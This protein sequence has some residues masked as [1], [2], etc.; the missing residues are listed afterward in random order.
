VAVIAVA[1]SVAAGQDFRQT[2][3]KDLSA[4]TSRPHRLAGTEPGLEA[5][6]YVERRLRQ[7]GVE[8]IYEQAVPV[9]Q[10]QQTE[11]TLTVSDGESHDIYALRP[12][13]LQGVVTP[14]EGLSG[15]T[16]YAGRGRLDEYTEWPENRIV[17]LEWD[18]GNY[19][20]PAFAMGAKAVIFI[21]S[22]EPATRAYH[23]VDLPAN[24][25][26]FYVPEPLAERLKL[27]TESVPV[28]LKAACRWRML[29]GRNV[30]GVIRGT[31]PKFDYDRDEAIVLAAPLDSYGEVPALARGARGAANVAALLALAE[32]LNDNRPRRDVILAFLDGESAGHTGSRFFYG[33]LY[34]RKEGGKWKLAPSSLDEK[35]AMLREE[36][37][38]VLRMIDVLKVEDM[39]SEEAGNLRGY[40]EAIRYLKDEALGLSGRV[41]DELFILRSEKRHYEKLIDRLK[42]VPSIAA[43]LPGAEDLAD[44]E[45]IEPVLAKYRAVIEHH[46]GRIAWLEANEQVAWGNIQRAVQKGEP[47]SPVTE[48]DVKKTIREY[49]ELLEGPSG[50]IPEQLQ[51]TE[52]AEAE[53]PEK[54][55]TRAVTKF[56]ELVVETRKVLR[57]RLREVESHLKRAEQAEKLSEAIGDERNL[58]V[59]H[60]SLNLGDASGRWTMMHGEDARKPHGAKDTPGAYTR[61]VF[62]AI[63]RM[64]DQLAEQAG[65]DRLFDS[66]PVETMRAARRLDGGPFTHSG[67]AAGLFSVPNMAVMSSLDRRPRDGQPMDVV[68]R[69]GDDGEADEQVFQVENTLASLAELLPGAAMLADAPQ[70][71]DAEPF[72]PVAFYTE[73]EYKNG[74]HEGGRIQMMSGASATADRPARDGMVAILP[75]SGW[76]STEVMGQPAGFRPYAITPVEIPGVF[77]LPPLSQDYHKSVR[78][79]GARFDERGLINYINNDKSLVVKYPVT[80]AKSVLFRTVGMTLV[81]MGYDPGTVETTALRAESTAP[82]DTARSLVA[83]SGKV[84]CV[85]C[86][87][88]TFRLKLFNRR[89]SVVLGNSAPHVEEREVGEG[90]PIEP[91]AHWPLISLTPRELEVLTEVRLALLRKHR[92]EEPSLQRL[93]ILAQE[94]RRRAEQTEAGQ[95]ARRAG[96]SAGAAG[97]LRSLYDPQKGVLNDLVVAVVLLLLLTIPFAYAM[98]RLLIG[99]PHIYRQI[100]WFAI[101]FL[102]ILAVLY[103]VNPAFSIAAT[104]I[105]IFL[106]FV[107]ILL[108]ALVIVIMARKLQAEV[109]RLQGLDTT[110]HSSDVSRLGTMMA[111]VHMG[112]STMRRRPIRTLLTAITVVLLT[113]TIL[114]FA[115]FSSSW[116]ARRTYQGNLTGPP[117]ML[118]RHPLWSSIEKDVAAVIAGHLKGEADVVPRYW[119]A[120]DS[121][122]ANRYQNANR[123]YEVTLADE[124]RKRV[125]PISAAMGLSPTDVERVESLRDLF[126][127]D[128]AGLASDGVYLTPTLAG[129]NGLDVAV[130]ERI[131][132]NGMPCT[133]AGLL[134]ADKVQVYRMLEGSELLPV[135][136][137]S[138]GAAATTAGGETI[139]SMAE[140]ATATFER[141]DRDSVAIVSNDLA[142][143]LGGRIAS[144]SIYPNRGMEVEKAGDRLAAITKLPVYVGAKGEVNRLIF[145][146]LTEASGWK[147]LLIPVIVGGL[148]IFAT[149]LGSVSDREREIYAFSALGLGPPHVASLFFAEAGVYS[150]VG[151]MG[152]YLLGQGVA[153]GV[154]WA[155][156]AFDLEFQL[157]MNYSSMNAIVTVLVVMATVLVSTIYPAVKA[158]RSANPGIQRK[159]KIPRPQGDLYDLVFP[160][161]VSAYDITGVVSFLREHFGNFSDTALGVFATQEVHAFRTSS[162]MLGLRAQVALAPFDLGVS[163]QFALLAEAS[164]IEGIEEIRILLHRTSGTRGDWQRANRVFIH[165]L[166]K[167]LLIWRSLSPEIMERY[168]QR[169]LQEWE[170]LP[171]EDV[172]PENFGGQS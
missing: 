136:Y 95:V 88:P 5:G 101:F 129:E 116:G 7:I 87:V 94:I 84:L 164:E 47:L 117:R 162:D 56:E 28:T 65:G 98:E 100:G 165:E 38:D 44:R 108:S 150:V 42:E 93:H 156:E 70:L 157:T 22:D 18:A 134:D 144:I 30:I 119:V 16:V 102:V 114:T 11:C 32:H 12:N 57:E 48:A 155:T 104:P 15:R 89:G 54:I 49:K 107:I 96:H 103:F 85:F 69:E 86:R 147:D 172:R 152:G 142:R 60:L 154:R 81:G 40:D 125:V 123:T 55:R 1:A 141:F 143:R 167:Q 99:T 111:A 4:L 159:W 63:G 27:R 17:V 124:Q 74:K 35:L 43:E 131:Y 106:A 132:V 9:A 24:L 21:G 37:Q 2:F 168:R 137:Q 45:N 140:G 72:K 113:F 6:R 64:A 97:I 145:T 135:D 36:R 10:S 31:D 25:P 109:G 67:V 90:R 133:F 127:G 160:F 110:V 83:E 149:M 148:I 3:R 33:A 163:Q 59:L 128:P 146:T 71:S 122:E 66:Q 158:S 46:R 53:L 41:R 14:P 13:L 76:Q 139:E 121:A 29:E 73:Y 78:V 138:S 115:S 50:E 153:R 112:I 8:E 58:I 126:I 68:V 170:S 52:E 75:G 118:I 120:Q 82:L 161:T 26:R 19:W 77:H 51:L 169:T 105:I 23:H 92:I 79:V 151:G 91:F 34:R 80:K 39:L 61:T 62:R 20:L 171:V 166:R 130:G